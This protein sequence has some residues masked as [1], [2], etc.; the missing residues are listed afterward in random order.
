MKM[1][2][3]RDTKVDH[4]LPPFLAAND[5]TAQR[6]LQDGA[7]DPTSLLAM[8]PEDFQLICI[9]EF[10]EQT[11]KVTELD[12]QFLGLLNDFLKGNNNGKFNEAAKLP[13]S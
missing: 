6:M 5:A 9:G 13:Q 2:T 1:Y 4:Y 3:C 7:R 10:N 12:H 8:H 11:G